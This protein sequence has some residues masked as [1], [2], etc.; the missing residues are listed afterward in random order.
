MSEAAK[1][2]NVPTFSGKEEDY[3]LFWPRFEAYADMKG[4]A[5]AIDWENPDPDL[6][7]KHNVFDADQDVKKRQEAAVKRNK[8]AIAAFTLAFQTKASLNMINEA[9]SPDYPRGL[10]HLVAKEL[11]HSCNPKDRVAKLEATNALRAVKMR[12]GSKP[13]MFFN[14]LKALKVQYEG[15]ITDE[16]IINEVMVKAPSQYKTIIA[17]QSM[18]KGAGLTVDDLKQAMNELYRLCHNSYRNQDSSDDVSDG[19]MIG[20]AFQ[21]ECFNCGKKGHKAVDCPD[22]KRDKNTGGGKPYNKKKFNG[23][24]NLCGKRGHM[25][26]DCFEL[27][28]NKDRR[29][30]G[31]K[32][33]LKKDESANAAVDEE[34]SLLCIECHPQGQEIDLF[35]K[36]CND[37]SSEDEKSTKEIKDPSD[38]NK[39]SSDDENMSF[40]KLSLSEGYFPKGE[41]KV[42]SWYDSD[43]DDQSGID[44]WPLDDLM[45]IGDSPGEAHNFTESEGEVSLSFMD[46]EDMPGL[47]E[48]KDSEDESESESED[49][50]EEEEYKGPYCF[51]CKENGHLS[52]EER[53]LMLRRNEEEEEYEDMDVDDHGN[54]ADTER[55]MSSDS[56]SESEGT[57]STENSLESHENELDDP[58]YSG[59]ENSEINFEE[60]EILTDSEASQVDLRNFYYANEGVNV[61][62]HPQQEELEGPFYPMGS[63]IIRRTDI[64]GSETNFAW[65]SDGTGHESESEID[66]GNVSIDSAG[67]VDS[68][69]I[70][71]DRSN[72][73]N[74]TLI[75]YCNACS[76]D[77]SFDVNAS[78]CT[79]KEE[80]SNDLKITSFEDENGQIMTNSQY[81]NVALA[82]SCVAEAEAKKDLAKSLETIDGLR[83]E[84]GNDDGGDELFH[85]V[86]NK[87]VQIRWLNMKNEGECS[88]GAGRSCTKAT[89]EKGLSGKE[90]PSCK[91]HQNSEGDIIFGNFQSRMT[92]NETSS[93][94]VGIGADVITLKDLA[95]DDELWVGDTGASRHMGK[96]KRGLVNVRQAKPSE[97]FT[98]GNGANARTAIVGDLVGTLGGKKIKISDVSYCPTAKFNLF[99]LSLMLKKGW[100]MKGNEKGIILLMANNPKKFMK[101]DEIVKTAKGVLFCARIVPNEVDEVSAMGSDDDTKNKGWTKI[102]NIQKLHEELGHMGE[103]TC[104]KIA[105]HVG[106]Q[107]TKGSLKPCEACAIAKSRQKNLPNKEKKVTISDDKVEVKEINEM[108]SIDLAKIGIPKDKDA[109]DPVIRNQHWAMIHD[110]ATG[111]KV[112]DFYPSKKM[113]IEPT[114][115]KIQVWKD[116]GKPVKRIRCDNAGENKKLEERLKSVDWKLGDIKFEYTA[117]YTPQQN[118]RVEKGFETIFNRGRAMLVAANIPEH[119][120]YLFA[121]EAFQTATKLDDLTVVEFKG[122]EKCR[123]QHWGEDIP[124]FVHSMI[125]WGWAGVVKTKRSFSAKLNN[126]GTVMMMVGYASNHTGDCYRMYNDATGRVHETRDVRWL[127]RMFFSKEGNVDLKSDDTEEISNN[128][129]DSVKEEQLDDNEEVNNNSQQGSQQPS[130]Q[131][132]NGNQNRGNRTQEGTIINNART[133]SQAGQGRT[134]SGRVSK[135]GPMFT[136]NTLGETGTFTTDEIEYY[137]ALCKTNTFADDNCVSQAGSEITNSLFEVAGVGAGTGTEFTNT[138]ELKPMKYKEAMK[139][140]DKALWEEAVDEEYRKFQK[141][142][143]FK[144]VKKEDVPKDAKFVTTT[145]AMKRKSNGVRRARMNMRGYEQEENIHYDP[146]STAAP[147]TNDV[148]IRMMLTLALMAGWT[149]HIIDVKGAFLHGEFE[150][151]EQIYTKIPEGFEKFWDPNIWVWLLMKTTYG[152]IQAA[153]QFWKT[154]LKAMRYMK[155]DRSRADPCLYWKYNESDGLSVWLSWVDDCCILGKAKAVFENKEKLKQL[156][157]CD[158]VGEL[159]EYVGCK[160]EWN[161]EKRSIKFTQPVLLQSYEDEFELPKGT[162]KTPAEPGKVLEECVENHEIDDERQSK[163]RSAVGKLLHMMRWS[164]PEIWNSVRECSRR[165]SRASEDH[166]KAVLRILKYC[167]DTKERGWELKPN[168]TW[169]GKDR[170][171][172]FKIRGKSDSNY[173]T[174]KE[175]RRSITGY[176]VWLEEALIAV[177]SGMQKIVALS[178]TEAEIIALVQCV[179]EMMYMKKVLESILLKVELPMIVEVDNKGAVDLV[180]G[181]SSS[182]GT[183]HMDVRI[184]YLRELKEQK[185]LKVVWQPTKENE[186]DVFTKNVDGATFERHLGALVSE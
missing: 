169:D 91:S 132:N 123:I 62:E 122:Q 29:P 28:K 6:P 151:G 78:D 3:E 41:L 86:A 158:D 139:C 112:S 170:S 114:C 85:H 120:R 27:E 136:Y 134:R 174:C 126:R 119:R 176:L 182:G 44:D 164:R 129:V 70:H 137:D 106:I 177:K 147:V 84:I 184:M 124:R 54:E 72:Y 109:D 146:S 153:V 108:I 95:G 53:L 24:C 22:K 150:N 57:S 92:Q 34:L 17:N 105:K 35:C 163:Y 68:S 142:N 23:T 186:A 138:E 175:T 116:E 121:K 144:P 52:E 45:S 81:K 90:W 97:S 65:V 168:R 113:M 181:W 162:F 64:D 60:I 149:G 141:Y 87:V 56:G 10:A 115:E 102:M 104:R 145:W 185:I 157:D 172:L 74:S 1:S 75:P 9:K 15:D 183:K 131:N 39:N 50:S 152:L 130:T 2:V 5:E 98:L 43:E 179:Q 166:M 118:S 63:W 12:N 46:Y 79:S 26:K 18:L 76:N 51:Y 133:R 49:E 38:S 73:F 173:A 178:V 148:T 159:K 93:E 99:S 83:A 167:A 156:F 103:Q 36:R 110:R 33:S 107:L 160:V 55:S 59:D 154:L 155:Y 80:D 31:W 77:E 20:G 8:T 11:Q 125:P 47:V 32:S 82:S 111:R 127:E 140:D 61:V 58:V 161:T 21:G 19:E 143:V 101:F 66:D 42:S 25:K 67:S 40:E 96:S 94:V 69:G 128:D 171:F 180:N 135:P 88:N 117:S 30:Q 13:S 100:V 7:S 71:S 165:M 16:M 14:K 89:V 4:F 37:L 48:K